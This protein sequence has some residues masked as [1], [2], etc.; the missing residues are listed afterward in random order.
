MYEI[1][2][3]N[4]MG[5]VT[6]LFLAL[7]VLSNNNFDRRTN[8]LFLACAICIL[9]Y[10][11]EEA[12]ERQLALGETY[13][14]LRVLLSA[15]GY[16]LRPMTVYFLV[17]IIFKS[18]AKWRLLL[19]LPILFNAVVAFSVLFGKWAFWYT[20]DNQ[21]AR[22]PLGFT[23]FATAG[24]YVVTLLVLTIL[25]CKKGDRMEIMTVSMI[26]VLAVVAT[27]MESVFQFYAIQSAT[28]GVSITFYYLFLHTNQN[29]R[30]SLTRALVRRRFYLDA[31]RYRTALTAVIS[32]DLNNLKELND[33]Y[34]HVAGDRAL[35]VMTET[36]KKCIKKRASLYR[37]GGDEF[38]V[39][40]YKM[41]EEKV[42]ALVRQIRDA[43]E[44]TE[45]RCAAGYAMYHYHAGLDYVC[46]LADEAMYE[47]KLRMKVKQPG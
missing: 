29:N 20:A 27:V 28:S 11:V 5:V 14:H 17:M 34:G 18:T 38:M 8:G 46:H 35:I 47:N 22:G 41:D 7:F 42:Q 16:M 44:N 32:L 43:M 2:Q 30:D 24:F 25:E 4:F 37:T 1:V 10:I 45:Y 21:F 26:V 40:C 31:E 3:Q 9:L 33:Q 13:T 36:V 6:V 12:W 39:L 23:P 19:S 15:V